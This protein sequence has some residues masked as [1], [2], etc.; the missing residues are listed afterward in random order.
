MECPKCK[1]EPTMAEQQASPD[2]CPAC[3]VVYAEVKGAPATG[4]LTGAKAAAA[5]SRKARGEQ[6]TLA[7]IKQENPGYVAVTDFNM[8][9]WSMVQFLVKLSLAAIPAA[10]ILGILAWGFVSIASII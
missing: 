8:P 3:G 6:E 7:R 4:G 5:A 10:V 9:F 1:H 2:V